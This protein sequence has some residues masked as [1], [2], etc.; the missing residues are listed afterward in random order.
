MPEDVEKE[1]TKKS[2]KDVRKEIYTIIAE[3][4]NIERE[5][6]KRKPEYYK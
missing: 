5:I 2:K 3:N 1:E 4:P 6:I